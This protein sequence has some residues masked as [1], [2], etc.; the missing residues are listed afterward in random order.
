M[1]INVTVAG[2]IIISIYWFYFSHWGHSINQKFEHAL[3][4]KWI[5]DCVQSGTVVHAWEHNW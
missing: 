1:L 2:C 5:G 3:P 4:F